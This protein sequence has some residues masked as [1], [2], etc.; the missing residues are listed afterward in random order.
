[1]LAGKTYPKRYMK[2]CRGAAGAQLEAYEKLVRA[3]GAKG[4]R[5]VDAF[6]PPFCG[7]LVIVLDGCFAHRISSRYVAVRS[8][9]L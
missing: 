3:A 8:R 4:A 6:E 1:M 9:S 5:P 2:A 7:N